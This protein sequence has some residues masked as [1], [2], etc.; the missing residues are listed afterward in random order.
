MRI[1]VTGIAGIVGQAVRVGLVRD[2]HEVIGLD[3]RDGPGVTQVLDLVDDAAELAGLLSGCHVLVHLAADPDPSSD[4]ASILRNNVQAT[5]LL[6]R[7]AVA[8]GVR[9]L[10]LTSSQLVQVA[11][12]AGLETGELLGL[13]HG[14]GTTSL[15]GVSKMWT[16]HYGRLLHDMDGVEVVCVR[17]GT[18]I[19]DDREH[20]RRGGRLMA[21]C[22]LREDVA[23]FYSAACSATIPG[24]WLVTTAQSDPPNRFHD[25]EPGLS[26]LG[27][28][29]IGWHEDPEVLL[30]AHPI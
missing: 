24:G 15:Y 6:G 10:V 4:D 3:R 9:R 28:E 14:F 27:W 8:A 18:V 17:L 21:T 12:E 1:A 11:L 25:L 26:V 5:T 20:W 2:G 30:G 16:E 13:E 22:G 7:A 29:P 23:R 19:A